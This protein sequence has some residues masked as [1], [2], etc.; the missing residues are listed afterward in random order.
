MK[1]FLSSQ[2]RIPRHLWW[3]G[4]VCLIG[5]NLLAGSL[6]WKGY[7]EALFLSQGGRT[8]AFL[9]SLPLLYAAYCLAAKRFQDRD[10]PAALAR[11]AISI[12]LFKL[13]LDL[14]H[15]TGDPWVPTGLDTVFLI[16][17]GG[18]GIWFI[19]E[20]GCMPGTAGDNRFGP[21][22]LGPAARPAGTSGP[23]MR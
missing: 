15:V 8:M 18:L 12:S 1:L 13:V 11:I 22:P 10:R 23:A 2:G 5:A 14:F 4:L 17:Q 9:V 3:I 6:L 7:G 19:V 21:D 16:V 20:L